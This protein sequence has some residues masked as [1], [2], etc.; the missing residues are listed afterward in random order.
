MKIIDALYD[1]CLETGSGI[2]TDYTLFLNLTHLVRDKSYKEHKLQIRRTT[3]SLQQFLG[4]RSRM[5][6][7]GKIK[8]YSALGAGVYIFPGAEKR[9][10][11][12]ACCF[13]DPFCYISHFSAMQRYRLTNRNPTALALTTPARAHW[14]EKKITKIK[15]DIV[16]IE[17]QKIAT[18]LLVK[19][20]FA[21]TIRKRNISRHETLHLGDFHPIRGNKTSRI[22]TIGQTFVD[23]LSH[24]HLCGGI[25][26]VLEVW[27]DHAPTYHD[28]IISSVE[29]THSN[30]VK[31]RAGYILDEVL[32][33]SD[34]RIQEWVKFAQRGS[35]RKLD[36]KAPY[37]P[38]FSE[39]WMIS[40]N[41]N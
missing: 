5:V 23:M 14:N 16:S 24:P 36:P 1:Y 4:L 21:N 25:D 34:I 8:R 38:I 18:T 15:N 40:I 27:K 20:T 10:I 28:Q 22:S 3:V 26:H 29:K 39:K 9:P 7:Y 31:V 6:R 2:I 19:S 13:V 35:S 12:E 30:I 17:E 11:E 32:K 33:S 41:V 37:Q